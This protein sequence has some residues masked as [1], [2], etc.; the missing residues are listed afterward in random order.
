LTKK[1]PQKQ[2]NLATHF[3]LPD[4]VSH[5]FTQ[6]R[7]VLTRRPDIHYEEP[8]T[9]DFSEEPTETETVSLEEARQEV[10]DLIKSYQAVERLAALAEKRVDQRVGNYVVS[11]DPKVDASVIDAIRRSFPE[12]KDPTKIS[13]EMYKQCLARVDT[14]NLPKVTDQDLKEA[15]KNP[16]KTDF[17][18]FGAPAGMNRPEVSSP[19]RIVDPIDTD[20]FRDG[21]IQNLFQLL[22]SFNI[23]Y[24]EKR[25]LEHIAKV[26]HKPI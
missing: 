9:D 7:E 18:G 10:D 2:G 4:L 17:S 19:A 23:P 14:T 11:L 24:I 13:Y 21:L 16:L 15:K 6:E 3:Q 22:Q 20:S 8:Y 25:F 5:D 12:A 1:T 26:P